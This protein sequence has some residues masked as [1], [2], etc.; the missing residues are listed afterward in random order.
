MR[1]RYESEPT[2]TKH[3]WPRPVL[4]CAGTFSKGTAEERSGERI[5][6]SGS[7]RSPE[8][9]RSTPC[10]PAPLRAARVCP[11][12]GQ[13][14]SREFRKIAPNHLGRYMPPARSP[15]R[16]WP[17]TRS[18]P[19]VLVWPHWPEM[20]RRAWGRPNQ[21]APSRRGWAR[22]ALGGQP[23]CAQLMPTSSSAK[24]RT[25]CLAVPNSSGYRT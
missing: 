20:D 25:L 11:D 21:F 15:D 8:S 10:S 22:T 1:I 19:T 18:A 13:W 9:R 4:Y 16:D 14:E 2:S 12:L 6:S 24:S 5:V 7:V 17:D 3:F 23:C